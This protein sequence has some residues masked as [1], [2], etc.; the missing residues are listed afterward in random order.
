MNMSTTNPTSAS[1]DPF[2]LNDFVPDAN[3]LHERVLSGVPGERITYWIGL[4][5][6]DRDSLASSLPRER[7]E[8][9]H[10]TANAA[11]RLAEAGWLHLLQQRVAPDCCAYIAVVRP[12]PR[13]V[14]LLPITRR[15]RSQ[16][17]QTMATLLGG[18]AA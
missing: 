15:R 9:L 10:I 17:E 5:A 16:H 14:P 1:R 3:S 2:A 4:L 8:E 12:R 18:A 6:R 7:R 13:N 11:M